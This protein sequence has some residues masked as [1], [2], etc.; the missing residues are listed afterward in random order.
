MTQFP[1]TLLFFAVE[2]VTTAFLL[3]T[4]SLFTK[5]MEG[6]VQ[7]IG[8]I[9]VVFFMRVFLL[10]ALIEV[11]IIYY[12]TQFGGWSRFWL[13]VLGVFASAAIWGI[14]S[15]LASRNDFG[16][17]KAAFA[18]YGIPLFLGTLFSWWFCYKW[19]GL[20]A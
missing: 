20:K 11:I 1:L 9:I 19:I 2:C 3:T 7:F 15:G 18:G 16:M 4:Y 5:P 14:F 12:A 8:Y 10:Q 17:L 6:V 13:I